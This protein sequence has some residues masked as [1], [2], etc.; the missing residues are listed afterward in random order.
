MKSDA[1]PLRGVPASVDAAFTWDGYATLFFSAGKYYTAP[2]GGNEVRECR[3][4][5]G[6]ARG[7]ARGGVR[8]GDIDGERGSIIEF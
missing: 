7:G 2:V 3:E 1:S 6:G 5:R 4:C 8:D